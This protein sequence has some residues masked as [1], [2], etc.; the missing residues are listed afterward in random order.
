[1]TDSPI[2]IVGCP[3]SGTT[4]LRNL[5]RSHPN[6]GFPG[7]SHFIPHFY[8]ACGNPASD[9]EAVELA[10]RILRSQWVRHWDLDL[11]PTSFVSCRTYAEVIDRLYSAF[12]TK[13]NKRRW[14]DKTPQYVAEIPTLVEIF[15]RCKIIHIYRDGR[16]VAL[17]WTRMVFGPKNIYMAARYW[18]EFVKA[19]HNAAREL[20]QGTCMEVCYEDLLLRTEEC[21]RRICAFIDEPYCEAV[22]VPTVTSPAPNKTLTTVDVNKRRP[23][24]FPKIAAENHNKWKEE[25]KP[26]ERMLFEAVAGKQLSELGYETEGTKR[27]VGALEHASWCTQNAVLYLL[28]QINRKNKLKVIHE[29]MRIRWADLLSKIRERSMRR[30]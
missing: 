7:E 18:R 24:Q 4:L 8:R 14:G 15:P 9:D 6:L 28:H 17:S 25:M 27:H 5:L 21:M 20:A 30:T 11:A 3:R 29:Y 2:F 1:M 19:G 10:A 26:A 23:Y 13:Q 12:S 22:T 16:D